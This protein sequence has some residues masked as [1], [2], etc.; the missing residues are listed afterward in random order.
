[1]IGN[2][3]DYLEKSI[4][5][6]AYATHEEVLDVEGVMGLDLLTDEEFIKQ[7]SEMNDWMNYIKTYLSILH[8]KQNLS[9]VKRE[10]ESIDEKTYYAKTTVR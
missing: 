4:K 8:M 7:K 6:G 3:V 9:R 5:R 1:M 2:F 10:L